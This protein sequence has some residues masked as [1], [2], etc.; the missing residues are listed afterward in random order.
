MPEPVVHATK[1]VRD[2]CQKRTVLERVAITAGLTSLFVLCYFGVGPGI[3]CGQ[4]CS[5]NTW[6]DDQI[7]FL[8]GSVWAYLWMLSAATIPLFVVRCRR[9]FHCTAV[10]YAVVISVSFICFVLFPVSSARLRP[11]DSNLISAGPSSWAFSTWKA[12][13]AYGMAVIFSV[14][15]AA[16]SICT[17]KQHFVV[18]GLGG[19][20]VAAIACL[21]LLHP[22]HPHDGEPPAW[23]WLGP[24]SYLAV[25][26]AGY[27][28]LLS[29]FIWA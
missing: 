25:V 24:T 27:A 2:L 21:V 22:Y 10:A 16:P 20:A 15:A 12:S 14:G 26:V 13:K 4:L 29:L 28:G 17:V 11:G 8:P 19:L 18:D 5:L 6:V 23:T 3:Y 7:P 9:L 1:S